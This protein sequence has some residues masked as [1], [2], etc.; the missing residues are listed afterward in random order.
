MTT[1]TTGMSVA[2]EE[3]IMAL[4]KDFMP[5]FEA[6]IFVM[7]DA[8]KAACLLFRTCNQEGF[9]V[10][11]DEVF[12]L[13]GYNHRDCALVALT[14]TFI[15]GEEYIEISASDHD[16]HNKKTIMMTAECFAGFAAQAQTSQGNLIRRFNFRMHQGIQML[17]DEVQTG[18]ADVRDYIK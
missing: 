17:L 15:L 11:L 2:L 10:D 3:Q 8:T 9:I 13:V 5:K 16:G 6:D 12:K 7:D 1:N 14:D 4:C 18:E